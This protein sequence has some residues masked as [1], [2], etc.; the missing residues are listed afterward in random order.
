MLVALTACSF[1][2]SEDD[3]DQGQT[4]RW[5]GIA[6]L[7]RERTPGSDVDLCFGNLIGGPTPDYVDGCVGAHVVGV[8]FDTI[9]PWKLGSVDVV[10]ADI[11]MSLSEDRLSVTIDSWT[12]RADEYLEL[13]PREAAVPEAG[14]CPSTAPIVSTVQGLSPNGLNRMPLGIVRSN[15]DVSVLAAVAV[16]Q[17]WFDLACSL[18][19]RPVAVDDFLVPIP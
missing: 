5:S 17:H 7:V 1:G 10:V 18:G 4:S 14:A 16:D 12:R 2:G 3:A 13:V 6:Y 8:D 11:Q 15:D 9:E 19:A